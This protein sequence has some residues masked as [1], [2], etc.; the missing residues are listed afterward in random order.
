M[1]VE[2]AFS[3]AALALALAGCSS[4][5]DLMRKEKGALLPPPPGNLAPMVDALGSLYGERRPVAGPGVSTED[6]LTHYG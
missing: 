4:L 3:P 6:V 5:S 2:V 1:K